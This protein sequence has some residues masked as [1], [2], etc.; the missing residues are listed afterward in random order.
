M[1]VPAMSSGLPMRLS[2]ADWAM[3]SP[4]AFSVAAIIFDSKGPGAMA[5][6]VIAGAR[7]LARCRVSWCTADFDAEY[8]YVSIWGTWLPSMD[9]ML[10]TR[11]GFSGD[12]ASVSWGSRNL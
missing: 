12:P 9:P 6:T 5:L 10:M 3:A 11:A 1:A 7:N 2:G 4:A 8:E